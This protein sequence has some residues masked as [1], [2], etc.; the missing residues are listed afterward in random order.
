MIGLFLMG[1][2]F[3][4]LVIGLVFFVKSNS[5][6]E[7]GSNENELENLIQMA[8][9]D[10][11]LTGNER[12][13]IKQLASEKGFDYDEIIS[14]IET[15]LLNSEKNSEVALIDYNKKNGEDFE[16]FI[17]QKFDKKYF[18][19]KEW[20]GD[21]FVNGQFAKTTQYPD[22]LFE[23][24][25]KNQRVELSV[26]CKWRSRLYKNGVEF[27]NPEQFKRYKDFQRERAIPVFVVIGLGGKGEKPE[28]IYVVPLK[29]ITSNFISIDQLKTYRKKIESDFFFDSTSN[30]L[31]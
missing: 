27:A 13:L 29:N 25:Y 17:I 26:E 10:G 30:E 28:Y 12:G 15:R 23:F 8:M 2:G 14:D 11:I 3:L 22:I 31:N 4:S 24:K 20:A 19:I 5:E 6:K 9:A 18:S 21:K 7:N 16:K 1:F